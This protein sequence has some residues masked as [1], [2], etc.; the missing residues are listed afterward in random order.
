MEI[1]SPFPRKMASHNR[2]K[3][4]HM[5]NYKY[6]PMKRKSELNQTLRKSLMVALAREVEFQD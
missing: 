1:N 3:L 6:C 2:A 4:L 5:F